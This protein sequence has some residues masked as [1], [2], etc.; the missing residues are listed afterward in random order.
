VGRKVRRDD[1][2]CRQ[3]CAVSHYQSPSN[4]EGQWP[5]QVASLLRIAALEQVRR[6]SSLGI[7]TSD[8]QGRRRIQHVARRVAW[9]GEAGQRRRLSAG[10]SRRRTCSRKSERQNAC[11]EPA[12]LASLETIPSLSLR[13]TRG[14]SER[15]HRHRCRRKEWAATCRQR[16][17]RLWS[18]TRRTARG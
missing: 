5:R 8:R 4:G 1:E 9:I 15:P 16:R 2:K 14:E 18:R 7:G 12:V 6:S 11:R 13:A 3:K 10:L 17:E